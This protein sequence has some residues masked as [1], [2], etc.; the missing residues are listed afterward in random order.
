MLNIIWCSFFIIPFVFA[1]WQSFIGNT[2]IWN[3]LIT[4]IF[5]SSQEA[6]NIT[7]NLTG[8][9]CLWLGLLKVAE[10]AGLTSVLAG[11][12]QPLFKRLCLKSHLIVPP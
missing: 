4:S 6:F 10:R 8:M 7:I 2:A 11:L 5:S 1:I 9:M 3:N 12:L